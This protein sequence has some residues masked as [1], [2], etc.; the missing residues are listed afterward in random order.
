[1]E[2]TSV[3]ITAI[4][5]IF[6]DYYAGATNAEETLHALEQVINT[7]NDGTVRSGDYH[8][9]AQ[10]EQDRII[11][12]LIKMNVLRPAMFY[13]GW[14]AMDVDGNSGVDLDIKLGGM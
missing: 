3:Q 11:D 7:P 8:L 9:G 6:N 13:E 12:Y 14:V 4:K 2:L 1:M 5:A 10:H